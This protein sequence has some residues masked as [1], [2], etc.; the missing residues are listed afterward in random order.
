MDIP[1]PQPG[2]HPRSWWLF[3]AMNLPLI[4]WIAPLGRTFKDGERKNPFWVAQT[5][6]RN[7]QL[8][9]QHQEEMVYK[10]SGEGSRMV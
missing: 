8:V 4:S 10:M 9:F 1:L 7:E 6:F 3:L 2:I 5:S